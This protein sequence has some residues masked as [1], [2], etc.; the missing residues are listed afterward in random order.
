MAKKTLE[1]VKQEM[2]MRAAELRG[3]LDSEKLKK[4]SISELQTK[5]SDMY[6]QEQLA[7]QYEPIRYEAG[8]KTP[9]DLD[10]EINNLYEDLDKM[11][12]QVV[13]ARK[14][15]DQIEK[16]YRAYN[17]V[18]RRAKITKLEQDLEDAKNWAYQWREEI[19]S[20][21]ID[22]EKSIDEKL[23]ERALL[24][25]N[26]NKALADIEKIERKL[27]EQRSRIQR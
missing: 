3:V 8:E 21:G 14:E 1:Q 6:K 18:I 15:L 24:M 17:I 25:Q 9:A 13:A 5:L 19:E 20:I 26:Y 27:H 12:P 10:N 2:N 23:T 22:P 11:Q 7:C 16:F 4:S